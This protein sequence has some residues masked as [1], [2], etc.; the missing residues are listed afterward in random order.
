MTVDSQLTGRC[1]YGMMP[2]ICDQIS[3]VPATAAQQVRSATV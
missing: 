1:E 3:G 2:L